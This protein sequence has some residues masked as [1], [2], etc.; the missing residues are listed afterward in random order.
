MI[1]EKLIEKGLDPVVLENYKK[2]VIMVSDGG[3]FREPTAE[4]KVLIKENG[5]LH[6][7]TSKLM[8][9]N[10]FNMIV[11]SP[12]D[13]DTSFELSVIDNN[14]II[15]QAENLDYNHLSDMGSIAF[16]IINGVMYR[17]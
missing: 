13:E 11:K 12:F 17:L 2:G 1:L 10:V 7:I 6:C 4:E 9:F 3:A 5:A 8:G 14:R 15:V 16:E